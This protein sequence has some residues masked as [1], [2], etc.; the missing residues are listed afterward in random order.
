VFRVGLGMQIRPVAVAMTEILNNL[1]LASGVAH[2]DEPDVLLHRLPRGT[3]IGVLPG[4]AAARHGGVA[5][6]DDVHQLGPTSALIMLAGIYYAPVRRLDVVD[7]REAAGESSSIVTC[8][9]GYEMAKQGRAGPA[10]AIAALGS[11]FGGCVGTLV[12]VF[13]GPI[14]ARPRAQVRRA[15]ELRPDDARSRHAIVMSHGSVA[16]AIGMTL[17]GILLAS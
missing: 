9:D 17:L 6:P 2:A 8:L 13:F 16:K 1:R 4:I 3:L 7:P 12:I 15:L 14:L 10:L 11:F 5:A